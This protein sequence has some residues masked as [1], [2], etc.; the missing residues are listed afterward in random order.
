M[1]VTIRDT[2]KV[3][4]RECHGAIL[5]GDANSSNLLTCAVADTFRDAD[6]AG[7]NRSVRWIP[8]HIKT[9]PS[10]ETRGLRLLRRRQRFSCGDFV[11]AKRL[12]KAV[13]NLRHPDGRAAR[14]AVLSSS[15]TSPQPSPHIVF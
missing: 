10:M 13:V 3:I 15:F 7:W 11:E 4:L 2:I 5:S 6:N 1:A 9:L 12:I 8:A 14:G